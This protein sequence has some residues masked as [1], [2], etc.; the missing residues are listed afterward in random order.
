MIRSI[1]EEEMVHIS[2]EKIYKKDAQGNELLITGESAIL[3]E[4][5]HHFQTIAGSINRKKP[6]Q[7]R[8]K[9]QYRPL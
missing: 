7:G 8:W 4:T 3:N 1:T 9:D 2:I 5:N 6:L